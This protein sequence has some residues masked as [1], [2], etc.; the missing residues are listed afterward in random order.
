[1]APQFPHIYKAF[2]KSNFREIF[3]RI[4]ISKTKQLILNIAAQLTAAMKKYFHF[5]STATQNCRFQP[6]SGAFVALRE[7]QM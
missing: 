4:A 2:E 7:M 1:I 3:A 5:N 6:V